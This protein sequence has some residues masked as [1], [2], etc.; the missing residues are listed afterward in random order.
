MKSLFKAI[1]VFMLLACALC[2]QIGYQRGFSYAS[3]KVSDELL[4]VCESRIIEA[5][6]SCVD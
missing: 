5:E 3:Q 6:N 1:I 4:E 2:Y